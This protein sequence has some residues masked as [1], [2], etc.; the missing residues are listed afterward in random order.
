MELYLFW[1]MITGL[2]RIIFQAYFMRRLIQSQGSM[3]LEQNGSYTGN[4]LKKIIKG[5][6]FKPTVDLIATRVNTQLPEFILLRPDPETK[7]VN[8][9]TL[10]W[11][12]LSFYAFPSF[13][14]ISKVL[15]KV[16]YG[17]EEGILV[18]PDWSNQQ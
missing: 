18:V 11:E 14:C 10:W 6:N 8:A 15:Q 7:G 4:I 9:F 13:I 3:K 12:N 17:K 2:Q 1:D 5:L 16:W